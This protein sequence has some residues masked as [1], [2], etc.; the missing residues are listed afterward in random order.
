VR[1]KAGLYRWTCT[2]TPPAR[3]RPIRACYLTA[4]ELA[5]AIDN[6]LEEARALEGTGKCAVMLSGAVPAEGA[7]ADSLQ[8]A[9]EIYQL[10]GVADAGRLAAELDAWPDAVT[11]SRQVPV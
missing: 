11:G 4:G 9:L 10:L 1:P 2:A 8:Q 3:S 7:A 5:R 6:Q